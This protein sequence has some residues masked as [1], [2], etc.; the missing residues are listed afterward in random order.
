MSGSSARSGA[1]GPAPRGPLVAISLAILAGVSVAF[2]VLL[3]QVLRPFALPLFLAAVFAVM[4]TPL[5]E[6][7][8]ERC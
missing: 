8:T 6:R 5:H 4:A 7:I 3:F 2:A 1:N